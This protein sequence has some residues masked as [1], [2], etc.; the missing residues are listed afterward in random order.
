LFTWK[1]YTGNCAKRK[2]DLASGQ[3]EDLPADL[4]SYNP[5]WDPKNPWRIVY[6][7][8]KGLIQL[9]ITTGNDQLLT[10]DLRDN[11]PVF[12]P[13]G[14]KLALTYK[15]HDH[16]EIYTLDLTTGERQRLTKPPLL[17]DPQYSS[18][19]PAWSSDG[20]EIAFITDRTGQWEI[21]AMNADGS[22]QHP[23]FSPEIQSQLGL[24]YW[25]MNERVL[26]WVK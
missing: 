1:I 8:E 18:A 9:D 5:A 2:V 21:W 22:N 10:D 7:G 6:S 26:N 17:A 11:D 20:R 3:F 23:L 25:G 24:Q 14:Q 16:W 15:Q 12:S 13:D 4:Y 19:S